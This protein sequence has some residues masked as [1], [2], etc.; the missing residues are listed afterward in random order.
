MP[1]ECGGWEAL[2]VPFPR[3]PVLTFSRR[4]RTTEVEVERPRRGSS[5]AAPR[6]KA[7]SL[8][9][10]GS[11]CPA[12]LEREADLGEE[13]GGQTA[14]VLVTLGDAVCGRASELLP[15]ENMIIMGVEEHGKRRPRARRRC[16]THLSR[17]W[18]PYI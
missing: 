4:S 1:A 18:F 15:Y 16:E 13:E 2:R 17:W 3:R 10:S 11:F 6:R 14:L 8:S 5:A 12:G 7:C 9:E